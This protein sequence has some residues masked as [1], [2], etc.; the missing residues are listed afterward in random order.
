MISFKKPHKRVT[1]KTIS[2]WFKTSL[3][4]AG[5]DTN[6]FK[7]HS[8]RS[9]ASGADAAL[10][11]IGSNSIILTGGLGNVLGPRPFLSQETP[12]RSIFHSRGHYEQGINLQEN[13]IFSKFAL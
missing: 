2:R 4:L 13:I 1:Q 11:M 3:K 6:V 9:A 12:S 7:G 10:K 8:I 5:I